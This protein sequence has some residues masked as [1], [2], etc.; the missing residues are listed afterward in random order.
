MGRAAGRDVAGGRQQTAHELPWR[1]AEGAAA[2]EYLER[3]NMRRA[4]VPDGLVWALEVA[5]LRRV[6]DALAYGSQP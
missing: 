6:R 2:R 1:S 3:Q 4:P 5:V